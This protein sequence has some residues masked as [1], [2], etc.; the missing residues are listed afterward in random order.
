MADPT[1]TRRSVAAIIAASFLHV[2]AFRMVPSD[3][4]RASLPAGVEAPTRQ[5]P[6]EFVVDMVR[7]ADE[8]A[9]PRPDVNPSVPEGA[10]PALS[11]GSPKSQPTAKKSAGRGTP[12]ESDSLF[13][14]I[15]TLV[16]SEGADWS[17]LSGEGDE[18][19][20]LLDGMPEGWGNGDL[21][22][23][24]AG[25]GRAA[26]VLAHQAELVSGISCA[27]LFPYAAQVSHASVQLEVDVTEAGVP[28]HLHIM[29]VNPTD[30][31][32]EAAA[33][34]CMKRMHF[35]PA[36]DTKGHAMQG[37]ATIRLEFD[38]T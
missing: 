24:P 1:H 9:E 16:S 20:G 2:A 26:N 19:G 23:S 34:R 6:T 15:R 38:R 10:P 13:E 31:G 22:K 29:S 5:L 28:H 36:T 4:L 33:E 30:E 8:V 14:S 32:F 25:G 35:K 7:P 37:H 27:D 18:M 11:A 12:S 3:E 21:G 17:A